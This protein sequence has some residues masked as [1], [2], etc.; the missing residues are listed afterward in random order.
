MPQPLVKI[1]TQI[2]P[3]RTIITGCVPRK[4]PIASESIVSEMLNLPC[5]LAL[6]LHLNKV[7][8]FA[9]IYLL[10]RPNTTR[11]EEECV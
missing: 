6:F 4:A 1:F 3:D 7:Q 5:S 10:L 9:Q 11:L 2:W 8:L